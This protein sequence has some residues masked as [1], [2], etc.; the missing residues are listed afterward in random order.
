M[1]P[2]ILGNPESSC[3]INSMNNWGDPLGKTNN[4]SMG[5]GRGNGIGNGNGNGMGP[6][7][8]YGHGRR[9][10]NAGTGGYG[11][12]ACLYCPRAEYS[13]AGHEGEGAG[14]GRA[15]C[16]GDGGRPRDGRSRGQGPR[17]RAR[18]EGDR[19]GSHVAAA[20]PHAA[21]TESPRRCGRL[22]KSNSSCSDPASRGSVLAS[23]ILSAGVSHAELTN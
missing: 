23:S 21:R 11:M 7:Q 12:P 4:D 22:S 6:G 16:G 19:S 8:R 2:T 5:Q 10:S 15:G 14:H 20:R 18:R 17:F 13:D 1:T 3:P 9:V